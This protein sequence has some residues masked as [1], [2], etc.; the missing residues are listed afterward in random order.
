[1]AKGLGAVAAFVLCVAPAWADDHEREVRGERH[2]SWTT[3]M[4]LDTFDDT[5][6]RWLARHDVGAFGSVD[7]ECANGASKLTGYVD[8]MLVR[9]LGQ[10]FNSE[11]IRVRVRV[12]DNPVTEATGNYPNDMASSRSDIQAIVDQ[13]TQGDVARIRT[14][15]GDE[16][17]TF[18]LSLDGFKDAAEWTTNECAKAQ[19]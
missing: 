14:E 18:Q 4:V 15:H 12:D 13:F 9:T 8:N 17:H 16:Q 5:P 6:V 19:R 2:G 10:V 3:Y 7:F 11:R 1:M